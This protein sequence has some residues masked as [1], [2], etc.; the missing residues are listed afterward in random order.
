MRQTVFLYSGPCHPL[1]WNIW[2]YVLE[3][4]GLREIQRCELCAL[5][6]FKR[7]RPCRHFEEEDQATDAEDEGLR[8]RVPRPESEAS[9]AWRRVPDRAED[10]WLS[11]LPPRSNYGRTRPRRS[12][13]SEIRDLDLKVP[14]PARS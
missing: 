7:V 13:L 10:K 8:R 1:F 5:A 14:A 9:A 6:E 11:A 3:C 2:F 12:L 4:D